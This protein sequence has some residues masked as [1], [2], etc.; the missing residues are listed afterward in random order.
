MPE[1]NVQHREKVA[2]S[3]TQAFFFGLFRQPQ[4]IRINEDELQK[5]VFDQWLYFQKKLNKL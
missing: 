5:K 3:L 1:P 2:A 4:L